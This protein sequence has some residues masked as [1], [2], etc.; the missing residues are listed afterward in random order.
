MYVCMYV[1]LMDVW[2]HI[3]LYVHV[4]RRESLSGLPSD[5][6]DGLQHNLSLST[7]LRFLRATKD[8][9]I[10]SSSK[11]GLNQKTATLFDDIKVRKKRF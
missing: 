4:F 10:P 7:S 8:G 6:F 1:F 3:H 5:V 11:S 2:L 9:K